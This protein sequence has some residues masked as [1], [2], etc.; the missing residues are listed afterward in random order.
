MPM[1]AFGLAVV[2]IACFGA[3]IFIALYL[4]IF[5]GRGVPGR[6]LFAIAAPSFAYGF[7]SFGSLVF[8]GPWYVVA[9]FF[10][11]ALKSQ[12]LPTPVWVVVANWLLTYEGYVVAACTL[13]LAVW[14]RLHI[15]PRWP[16]MIQV[17]ANPA[18]NRTPTGGA[19]SSPATR[20]R[21]T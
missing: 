10:T 6:W 17:L 19:P 21:L 11:P 8:F 2:F 16:A 13:A 9:T 5:R 14:L 1:D 3:P 18:F 7:L 20:G 4:A 12:G 15:W